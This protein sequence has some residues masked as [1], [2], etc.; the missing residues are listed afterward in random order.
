MGSK[1]N[2]RKQHSSHP[3][4]VDAPVADASG[5]G[6]ASISVASLVGAAMVLVASVCWAYWPTL[7]ETFAAWI[8]EPDYSHG[9]LVAPLAI[10]FLY[11]RRVEFPSSAIRPAAAGLTLLLACLVL[12]YLAGVY[13]LQPLDRWTIPLWIM[14]CVWAMMGWACLRWA[15]PCL[16]FLWFMFPLPY[17]AET[18]L[19]VPLQ[20]LATKLSSATLLILGLPVLAEGNTI[21]VGEEPLLVEE[22]CSGLRIFVGIFALAFAF[23]IFSRW[24]WWQKAMTLLAAL[25]IAIFANVMRIVGT[26]LL[27]HFVSGEAG[28]HFIHDF[29]GIAMIPVAALMFWLFV[30]YLDR[31]LPEV[32]MLS[33]TMHR[34]AELQA[35][36]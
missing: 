22:A 17:Q 4:G 14:G 8:K 33:P 18:L 23:V 21:W 19:S 10:L 1:K 5:T 27:Y 31:L 20:S 7:S 29:S 16:I 35:Q 30:K 13:F 24:P 9:F 32:E 2:K 3:D 26:G 34:A 36:E 12:R 25:P 28:R 6:E 11:L 15:L